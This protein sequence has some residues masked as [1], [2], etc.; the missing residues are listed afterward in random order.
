MV[1]G[2]FS[3]GGD[4]VRR[5]PELPAQSVHVVCGNL[6]DT[7]V[8]VLINAQIAAGYALTLRRRIFTA[9]LTSSEKKHN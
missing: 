6:G 7:K 2:A 9:T 5:S 4:G 1:A 3:A 8:R